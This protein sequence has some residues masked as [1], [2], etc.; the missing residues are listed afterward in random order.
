MRL[1]RP[2]MMA[3]VV[4]MAP[5]AAAAQQ[6]LSWDDYCTVGSLQFCASVNLILTPFTTSTGKD[7]TEM[8]VQMQNLEG[9]VGTTPWALQGPSF[10][11]TATNG[12][13]STE[14][15]WTTATM[16]GSAG[17]LTPN[18]N[19]YDC[20]HYGCPNAGWGAVQW[21]WWVPNTDPQNAA[22]S[23]MFLENENPLVQ[24]YDVV[25]CAAPSVS[26]PLEGY[27]QT[28]GDG[29]WA[30]SI[31]LPGTWTFDQSS[32]MA[33]SGFSDHG[34]A[35]CNT[36]QG[37]CAEVTPEPETIVLLGTGLL[38]LGSAA[39]RRRRRSMV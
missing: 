33:W 6:A 26:S 34:G 29:W 22:T 16:S 10:G 19:T 12:F 24:P 30:S 25:G 4:A 28:C 2:I 9:T 15:Q 20:A 13:Y 1:A 8:T 39:L 17:F 7:E 37:T 27:F 38:G 36:L 5:L 3:A 32:Y 21:A 18:P 31:A 11:L 14:G 23:P 35:S